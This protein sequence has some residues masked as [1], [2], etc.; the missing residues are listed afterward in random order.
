MNIQLDKN[1]PHY[2]ASLF[3]LLLKEGMTPNQI[4]VGIVQLATNTNELDG[5]IVSVD[6][7]RLLLAVMPIDTSA[8]GMAE[9]ISSL[10]AEGVTT[11]M[12]LDAL[13][14]ACHICNLEDAGKIIRLTYQRLQADKIISQ[15]LGD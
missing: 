10:A 2:L 4:M 11:L 12:L 13:G 5:M 7:L 1:T 9:F 3:V 6:C 8:E 14:F 15:V